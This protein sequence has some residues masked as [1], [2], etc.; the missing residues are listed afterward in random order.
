VSRGKAMHQ[1]S[2]LQMELPLESGGEASKLQRSGEAGR[3]THAEERSGGDRSS[4][5]HLMERVI[6]RENATKALKRVRRNKGSPGIDGMTVDELEPYLRENWVVIRKQRL[7]GTY[8]PNAVKRTLILKSGGGMRQLGI[9]TVLDRFVQQ[10]ILQVLQPV[11]DPTFSEHSHG[12]RPGRRAHDAVRKAQQ[13]IQ[14]RKTLG[15]GRGLGEILRP[16]KPRCVDGE[17]Q[18]SNR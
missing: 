12:F 14:G 9:P 4:M 11:F 18:Q 7:S 2:M 17:A 10:L 5:H 15:G 3:A 13:Y 6:E 16:R 1:K 8:R